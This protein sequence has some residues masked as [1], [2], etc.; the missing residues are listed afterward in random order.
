MGQTNFLVGVRMLLYGV[1]ILKAEC[2][3]V[4]VLKKG[5]LFIVAAVV[6]GGGLAAQEK[7][8]Q[9]VVIEGGST[10]AVKAMDG[11]EYYLLAALYKKNI[12]LVLMSNPQKA[13][14]VVE[15]SQTSSREY[16][17]SFLV[18]HGCRA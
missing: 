5:F 2:D 8:A 1:D 3:W 17:E 13:S 11:F 4:H 6:L 18:G 10:L 9:I 7:S 16:L 12:P 15:G 14:Y